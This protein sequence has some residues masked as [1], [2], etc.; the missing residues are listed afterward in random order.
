[1]INKLTRPENIL[2]EQTIGSC[3]NARVR[4]GIVRYKNLSLAECTECPPDN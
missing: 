4:I 2:E 1:M 3:C